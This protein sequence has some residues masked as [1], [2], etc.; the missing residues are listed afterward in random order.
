MENYLYNWI[1]KLSKELTLTKK[2]NQMISPSNFITKKH[3]YRVLTILSI[4]LIGVSGNVQAQLS[5]IKT[6]PG[7]YATVAAAITAVNG[8]GVGA[9]GVTFNVAAGHT[10]TLAGKIT[11]T[12]TGTLADPIVFQKSGAGANPVLTAYVGT[13]ATP[14]VIADGFFVLA[15]SDYITI[16]GI[17]LTE[18]GANTTTT[19][20]MEFGYGLYLASAT[21]GCQ[22]NV[23][24]NCTITLNRIQNTS[25]TAPGHNGSTGIAILN[26]LNTATGAVTVTA[27]SGANSFNQISSNTIQNCNAGIVLVGY[28]APSPFTLGNTNNLIG[29]STLA[30]GNT[31]LNYGGGAATNPATGIFASNQWG[32]NVSYNT[33]NNNNGSGI[34]H[35]STLRG[36]FLNGATSAS[37]DC[38]FNNITIKGG[39]TTSQVA[40]IENVFGS[41]A[42]GNTV[43]I[44]NNT[45]TGEYLTATSGVFY[46][47]FNNATAAT[48][49]MN[50][51]NISNL[52][53]S[54]AALTGS[55]VVYPIFNSGAAT[56]VN[57]NGNSIS[58]I[59]RIGTTGGTTIG[60]YFSAGANQT[61]NN[62]I[63]NNISIDGTGTASIIYG[64]Q[65]STSTVVNNGNTISNLTC[66]KTS[67]TSALYGIYNIASPTN[68]NYNNNTIYNLTHNGTGITYGLNAN[69]T[70]GVR[71]VSGNTVYSITSGG[72][73][74][75]GITMSTS[76][77]TIYNNKIFDISS[78]SI[79]SP[80]VSGLTIASLGTAGVANVYNNLIGNISAPNAS[81][82][83]AV[84]PAVR[85]INITATTT[86]SSLFVSYNTIYLN[87]SSTGTDFGSAGIFQST[88]TTAT[89][90]NLTLR[91]NLIYNGSTS[92]GTGAT[93]A[94]RRSLS[95]GTN[96]ND[97]SNNNLFWAGSP[98]S[99]NLIYADGTNAFDMLSA[100]QSYI[101]TPDQNSVTDNVPF[102]T[103]SGSSAD[104]L[105]FSL[106]IA[107]LA[108]SGGANIS[109]ITNDFAGVIRQGNI[110]YGGT[111]TAPDIG[112]WE[113]EGPLA[114]CSGFPA[115]SSAITSNST[116]CIQ[117]DFTLTLSVAYGL[118]YSYQWQYSTVSSTGP[119]TDV[120]GA[121]NSSLST[122]A[123]QQTWYQ[124]EITCISS[125]LTTASSPVMVTTPTSSL[126]GIYS[127]DNTGAGDY[128]T[129][130]D[131][132][133]DVSCRG[134]SGPVTF[135]VALAS[136]TYNEQV[137]IPF[138][139]G[140]SSVNT[141]TF[142]GN[143]KTIEAT[144]TTS[145]RH[146]IKI[147]GADFITI[148][149]LNIVGLAA[150][151]DWGIHLTN[152]SDNDS[153]VNCTINLSANTSTTLANSA[154][155]V[156][157]GSSISVS[158]VGNNA[159]NLVVSGCTI[160]GGYT[161]I[162]LYGNTGSLGAIS[163]QILNNTVQDFY[164]DGIVLNNNDGAIVRGN[165]VHRTNSVAVGVFTGI[166]LGTAN[167]NCLVDGNR[168]HDSHTS[169]T[170]QSGTAYGI[171]AIGCDAPV[172]NE[173][174]V[175]NNLIYKLNSGTGTIYG[176]Y[177][178]SSNGV[179]YYHNTVALQN[180]ASTAGITRGFYQITLA[181]NIEVKNNII[182]ITRGGTD[183]KNCLYFGT[184][185]SSIISN[186]NLLFINSAAGTN[187]IG[188]YSTNQVSLANWQAVN[189]AS[190][191]Q[192][193]ISVDPLFIDPNAGDFTPDN[194]L[195]DNKGVPVGVTYDLLNVSRSLS[196]PD[197]GCY[198]FSIPLGD[199]ISTFALVS[200]VANQCFSNAETVTVRIKNVGT[201]VLNFGTT[202]V[203]VSCQITGPINTTLT[204][205]ASGT[206]GINGVLDVVL[207]GTADMS[208]IG[209][210][211]IKA[212]V[213][214][215]GDI[216][217]SNDTLPDVILNTSVIPGTIAANIISHCISGVSNLTLSGNSQGIIQWQSS[218]AGANG[219]WTNVGANA[220]THTTGSL[221]QTTYYRALVTCFVDVDSTNVIEIVVNN[222]IVLGTLPGL[223]CGVGTVDLQATVSA[224]ASA[225]WYTTL[226]GGTSI[227]TGT[228]FTTPSISTTTNYYVSASVGNSTITTGRLVPQA[229]AGTSLTT[230][231]MDF[232]ITTAT[233]L[234]SVKVIS[235]TGTSITVSLYSSGGTTQLQTTGALSVP[236]NDTT[237]VNLNWFLAPGTY[238]LAANGMTGDFIREN[239]TVTYP[240]ALSTLGQVNGFV[241]SLTGAVTTTASYY[242]FYSWNFSVGC[243][244]VRTLVEA[245]VTPAP[246]ISAI[247]TNPGICTGGSADLSVSS[248][249]DPNYKYTWTSV[250]AGF[251]ASGTGPHTIT[252]LVSANYIVNAEDTTG[253]PSAGCTAVANIN[254]LVVSSVIGGTVSSNQTS[255]C[256]SG[257]PTLTVTGSSG[258]LQW[259][260]STVSTTGPWTN[261]GT[262][263]VIHIPSS[264]LTQT[265]YYS[266]VASCDVSV[267]SSNVVTI[268]VDSPTILSTTP[269][270]KCGPGT[271]NLSATSSSDMNW[272]ANSTGG[273]PLGTG[274]SFA[275]PFISST[276]DF[277]VAAAAGVGSIDLGLPNNVGATTNSGYSDIG[278]MFNALQPFTLQSVAI[279]PVATTPS[280]DVTVTI[281]LK[282]S[283]GTTL[284]STTVDVPTS[285][286]PGI[287][288][289]IPLNFSVPTGTQ[290][291]L[292]FTSA[293]GGGI[294]GFIREAT[295]GYTYPYTAPG[296]ASITSAYTSGASALYYY[297]FYDWK[298][299]VGCES[300]RVPVTATISAPPAMTVTASSLGVCAGNS[301]D[302]GVTSPNDPNYVYT[303]T[304]NPSGFSNSGNGPFNIT[305]TAPTTYIV[306]AID[307]SSG[308]TGGCTNIDSVLIT[309]VPTLTPGVVSSS[310]SDICVSGTPTLSVAGAGG[311]IQWQSSTTSN[312]GPWSNVGTGNT[313]YIPTAPVTQ[314][315]Y[316]RLLVSCNTQLDS[317]NVVTVNV[318]SPTL[319]STTG[320]TRCG[321]GTLT[322]QATSNFGVV[323]WYSTAS[324]GTSLGTGNS[325][326]TPVINATTNFYAEAG[327]GGSNYVTALPN[328]LAT[329]TSGAGLANFGLVFNALSAFKLESVK[330]YPLATVANTAGTVTIDVI[331][332]TGAVLHSAIV[333]VLGNPGG[334]V[335]QTVTLNF[336]IV[337]GTNL[338]LRA[339]A[340]STGITGLLFEP[341]A[342][343]P[344]G[345]YG[346][347]YVIPGI[348]SIN[349]STLTAAPTNTPRNDL[350]YYFYNW[351]VSTGCTNPNRVAVQAEVTPSPAV[352]ISGITSICLG[353]STNLTISTG[354]SDY[355]TF[356]WFPTSS[357]SSTSGSSIY[358]KPTVTTKYY[359]IAS[360]NVGNCQAIDSIT[361]NVIDFPLTVNVNNPVLCSATDSAQISTIATGGTFTYLWTPSAGLSADNIPNP[362][363]R[364]VG[365]SQT[366]T[367]TVTNSVTGCSKSSSFTIYKSSPSILSTVT[368]TICG[369]D[370]VTLSATATAG[371]QIGWWNAPT[372]GTLLG[373]GPTFSSTIST[374]TNFYVEAKDTI[375]Q[376]PLTT[377]YT[378]GIIATDPNAAG[379]MFDITALNNIRVT[380]F[381]V[382][383]NNNNALAP[384]NISVYYKV[385]SYSGFVTNASAWTLLDSYTGLVSAGVGVPTYLPLNLD[386]QINAG[387]T[388]GIYIVV[389]N[390]GVSN[391]LRY[392]SGATSPAEFAVG[393]SDFNLQVKS[394]TICFG[395]FTGQVAAPVNRLW[396]GSVLYSIGCSSARST[397]AAIALPAPALNV[398]TTEDSVCLGSITNVQVSSVNDPNYS[399]VWTPNGFN[400]SSYPVSPTVNTT[401][402]VTA[403]D[404][405][406]G[407]NS[408][409]KTSSSINIVV[410]PV[411]AVP[412]ITQDPLIVCG[413][414]PVTL[415]ASSTQP[416]VAQVG[417]GTTVSSTS[418]QTPYTALYEGANVQYLFTAAELNALNINA[419]V[420][421]SI[422]FN[423]TTASTTLAMVNYTIKMGTTAATSLSTYQAGLTQVYTVPT[424]QPVVGWNTHTLNT[425]FIWDGTSN[426]LVEVCHNYDPTGSCTG[427]S[428]VCYGGNSTI[429]TSATS[430]T[431]VLGKYDDNST[432][433]SNFDPCSNLFDTPVSTTGTSR[434]NIQLGYGASTNFLWS[435]GATTAATT[436]NPPGGTTN[437]SVVVTN[438]LGCTASNSINVTSSPLPK[439]I[440]ADNDTTLCNPDTINVNVIDTGLYVGGYPAGTNFT[441]SAIGVPIPDLY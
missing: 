427:L 145:A 121:T 385:G 360:G 4:W 115:A 127:I 147:S 3:F 185:T 432:P 217:M 30:D 27:A 328:A 101:V 226:T 22:N 128:L 403:T 189:G 262:G 436:V 375:P 275:T 273:L 213:N 70:T 358:A 46:G 190:Y 107:S 311:A 383:L 69:T 144:P 6:I 139:P 404:T 410:N 117:Q 155:I 221:T 298:L 336:N 353:D 110:G 62:N 126:S 326:V 392:S 340:R 323:K 286:S 438:N 412:T 2:F 182:Y 191:D 92:N 434:P 196:T 281:A 239:S 237:T 1:N 317:S 270:S 252:P 130:S 141:V 211:T 389:T 200:P 156:A 243:E 333:N 350:Y 235:T 148:K 26:G 15:G 165:N 19:Q 240:I 411:P 169:A 352:G 318:S 305:P 278:L 14:S 95:T 417:T 319:L 109:G 28:A 312:S 67:G 272:Y 209:T 152:G 324:G 296:Y 161:G 258:A 179:F 87:S 347:P 435:T 439:P 396:N 384:S 251:T 234:Q 12:A 103:V 219:P 349:T 395:P 195:S 17:N 81:S 131:A 51:N 199:D 97:N 31:I 342:S 65:T 177:N 34:N 99:T 32:L 265:T 66:L 104:F 154:G 170:T 25:W 390:L 151:F 10:E 419:G 264:P 84:S 255:F 171:A 327:D 78:T 94:F 210:Y 423:V 174:K 400:G 119:W 80:I 162:I 193:S 85:G 401:Y 422:A 308:L 231:G 116:P 365:T 321:L 285:V 371:A 246:T 236:T 178:S 208:T 440:I 373:T 402:T 59:S 181:S 345:N 100:Y 283:A 201:N 276:T 306:S 44:N 332:G 215:S 36:I 303:W 105:K 125:T 7:D 16:D 249:N 227:G 74:V 420:L 89:S 414:T 343:A 52:S 159:S 106:V 122:N 431:S 20:V 282:N 5:G 309:Y 160:I 266:V 424:Y 274:A 382:H 331:D 348:L 142:N 287:K 166:E 163:N 45:I 334:T 271:V 43:N 225:N 197:V 212:F 164:A 295:T 8:A 367:V 290:H 72:T 280:G 381:N 316:Y 198:E 245:T 362:K 307:T 391:S 267:D 49:N 54:N 408:G 150:D 376:T 346:Y 429:Q 83:T 250:P 335:G 112:A 187:G 351:V 256:V 291:R 415:T 82:N 91:N 153:I 76:S 407:N 310:L 413:N 433:I 397:V 134:V 344:S 302:I 146:I 192:Q 129:F 421:T 183:A 378:G 194:F 313:S 288:T 386:L 322:L 289:I 387:Q 238:R 55:G 203:A 341:A 426:L 9:G 259:R 204:G 224:G 425:P 64:I 330:I 88:S 325:F 368:D 38:N 137:T 268:I 320:A 33:I 57:A 394:G 418:G 205:S 135:N 299:Q 241:S 228:T 388:Y 441:W 366:Y 223:R 35:A 11:L 428:G 261:V 50:S 58:N 124:C 372:G 143:G 257:T 175:I 329:A 37:V 437:Y 377:N 380:G 247:T 229:G 363:V 398:T 369:T 399:Y 202:P 279:Y 244:S 188:F 214:M 230:Y 207:S 53:Y 71:T 172:G 304:S 132:A 232:T 216:D 13:V 61:A 337:P 47:I 339:S 359:V 354:L 111:G 157:S 96:Y 138:I 167:L 361:I 39:A 297:Y 118:G 41:T 269:G 284:Q 374:N 168:V 379:N 133:D 356:T 314:T 242:W 98:S 24:K 42:A 206:L 364:P 18:S 149:N 93:V 108:E 393:A 218:T 430:F 248:P 68:E 220:S 176:L 186:N 114:S 315:T 123:S 56:N 173:N 113:L 102:Q 370:L 21:N 260:R 294:T 357:L 79:G 300:A 233:T 184:T 60:I 158:T 120:S 338:K 405:S 23:I 406:N 140:T 86:S 90:A 301:V 48:V 136:T 355:T 75:A 73:T 263:G 254:I 292:V 29:G 293:T 40:A 416:G 277:W 253:G 77:P 222:P 180:T 63:I 409:C